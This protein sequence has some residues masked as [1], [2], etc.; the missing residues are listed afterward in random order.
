MVPPTGVTS[1]SCEH[2]NLTKSFALNRKNQPP[3]LPDVDN[4]NE[5]L[6]VLAEWDERLNKAGVGLDDLEPGL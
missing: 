6:D 2:E 3:E 1:N 4:L 5:V